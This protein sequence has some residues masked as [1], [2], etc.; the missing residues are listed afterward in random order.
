MD[1][2]SIVCGL[3]LAFVAFSPILHINASGSRPQAIGGLTLNEGATALIGPA[4]L[5]VNADDDPNSVLY[6]LT[7]LPTNGTLLL[8]ATT[9]TSLTLGASFAQADI[10]SAQLRYRHN[11]AELPDDTFAFVAEPGLRTTM[12]SVDSNGDQGRFD[13]R[14]PVLSGNGR[15]VAFESEADDLVAD[16]PNNR[17]DIFVRDRDADNDG[18]F[19]EQGAMTTAIISVNSSDFP[20]NNESS[21]AAISGDGRYVVFHSIATNLIGVAGDTNGKRDAFL[22]DRDTDGDGLFDEPGAVRTIRI[23][24]A[25]DG[26]QGNDDSQDPAITP[27]GRFVSFRSRASNLTA[28][29]TN[30]KF[31]IFVRDRDVDGDGIYDEAGA[32]STV[33]VSVN[34]A[35]EEGDDNTTDN[36][37]S[38]NGRF[39][40]YDSLATNLVAGD[41]N[42][43]PDVFVHDRDADNDGVYDETG[44]IRTERVSLRFDGTQATPEQ[45]DDDGSDNPVMSSN[46]RFVAFDSDLTL[47][48]NEQPGFRDSYVH[49]RDTD[50]DGVFDEP[51]ARRTILISVRSDGRQ[52]TGNSF[53]PKMSADGRYIL[54]RSDGGN[55]VPN[56]TNNKFDTFLL[57]R[58]ADGDTIY[59]EAGAIRTVRVSVGSDS[60]E[61]NDGSDVCAISPDGRTIAFDSK[62]TNLVDRDPNGSRYD[63]FVHTRGVPFAGSL[64]ISITPLNDAPDITSIGNQ[65]MIVNQSDLINIAFT[66]EDA[67]TRPLDLVVSKRTSNP[68]VISDA[69]LIIDGFP[70]NYVLT[71]RP[72]RD[73]LGAAQVTLTVSDGE[74]R[75]NKTFTFEVVAEPNNAPPPWLVLLYLAGD[76]IEPSAEGQVGLSGAIDELLSRLQTMPPNP[77][78]RLVIFKD[79]SAAGD[80]A[81]FVRNPGATRLSQVNPTPADFIGWPAGA[82]PEL[83]SGAVS[84]LRNFITW[85]RDAYPG[86]PQSMLSIVGHGGGWSPDFLSTAQPRGRAL[87]QSGG[88]RGLAIDLSANGRAGSSLSTRNTSEVFAGLGRFDL[89]F[90]DACLMAMAES[91]YEVYPYADYLVAGENLLWSQ[92]PYEEYLAPTA[93]TDTTTGRELAAHI[94]ASYNAPVRPDEPFVIAG[95]ASAELPAVAQRVDELAAALLN[96]LNGPAPNANAATTKL[97]AA[98]AASQKLDYDSSL[99]IEANEGYVDLVDLAQKLMLPEFAINSEISGLAQQVVESVL[100]GTGTRGALIGPAKKQSGTILA[101]AAEWNFTNANGLAIYLPLGERD[102]RATGGPSVAGGSRAI[103]PC[104]STTG[105][106]GQPVIEPQL[107]TYYSKA[108]Q[109]RFTNDAPSWSA[110]L[111]KLDASTADRRPESLFNSPYPVR[112]I[113]RGVLLPRSFLPMVIQ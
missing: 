108:D 63:I 105:G 16:D 9:P 83:D 35:G 110:L 102:C 24:E 49:D 23:S 87:V 73:A 8:G 11:G 97:R 65:T 84:T 92:F 40:T 53:E 86:S 42:G 55:L 95:F 66:V 50:N 48:E 46:G 62:A 80:T 74:L 26:S 36:D 78:M 7:S 29:D 89:L 13:S 52:G 45:S 79:G 34:D 37:L 39:I 3:L 32:V 85:A 57:D 27:D 47:G 75:T 44:A 58:D 54:V 103:S 6:T 99:S 18:L 68:G 93:L 91:L 112:S 71:L 4:E 60:T 15:F 98:Y 61:G 38:A 101:G 43:L 82:A 70:P 21:D 22:R 25:S 31:D 96:V 5:Q 19:D 17:R 76:D 2:R 30:A 106:D 28:G 12:A 51:E 81:I 33:I 64:P 104:T 88:G 72:Q 56:D 100:G 1:K 14:L 10:N 69:G 109:L 67:E 20:A 90:F 77:H 107:Q 41:T 111:L 59:D 94:V 113:G